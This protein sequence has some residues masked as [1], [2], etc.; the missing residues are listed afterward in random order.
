MYIENQKLKSYIYYIL[1]LGTHFYSSIALLPFLI[2]MYKIDYK[3]LFS[4]LV[5][6]LFVFFLKIPLLVYMIDISSIFMS[7]EFNFV[8]GYSQKEGM[9]FAKESLSLT[10]Y[11]N[12]VISFYILTVRKKLFLNNIYYKTIGIF[13]ILST[14]FSLLFYEVQIFGRINITLSIGL[15][16]WI[17]MEYYFIKQKWLYKIVII[18]FSLVYFSKVYVFHSINQDIYFPY[19]NFIVKIFKGDV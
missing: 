4:L 1:A 17:A 8:L 19:D 2:L 18:L 16:F 5:F 3:Y 13:I 15:A 12:I 14:V 6:S 10:T 11:L 9:A 7:D